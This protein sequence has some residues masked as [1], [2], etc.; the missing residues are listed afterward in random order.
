MIQIS[1][2]VYRIDHLSLDKLRIFVFTKH[3][4]RIAVIF[5]IRMASVNQ[6][7]CLSGRQHNPYND[8]PFSYTPT[9][10]CFVACH[11]R[12]RKWELHASRET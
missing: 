8:V 11:T 4:I 3:T 10:R 6:P 1:I 7:A 12:H 9:Y 5:A 2:I